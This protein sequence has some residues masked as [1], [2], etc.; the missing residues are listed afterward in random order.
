MATG[1]ERFQSPKSNFLAA[2]LLWLRAANTRDADAIA[3]V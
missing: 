1:G 2:V 3:M